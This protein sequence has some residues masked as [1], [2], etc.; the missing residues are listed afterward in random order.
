MTVITVFDSVSRQA[1]T[2]DVIFETT[3]GHEEESVLIA[4]T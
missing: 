4:G 3:E 1:V 2:E